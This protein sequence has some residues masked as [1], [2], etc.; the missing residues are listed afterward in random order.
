MRINKEQVTSAVSLAAFSYEVK[1]F[2][3]WHQCPVDQI[4]HK[5]KHPERETNKYNTVKR[6]TNIKHTEDA[7]KAKRLRPKTK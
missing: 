1:L 6:S 3:T 4:T 7:Q 2:F 5:H